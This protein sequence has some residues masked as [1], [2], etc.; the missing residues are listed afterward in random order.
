MAF[1]HGKNTKV[2]YDKYDLSAYFNSVSVPM[3]ADTSET[4]T[5]GKDSKT[6]IAGLKDAT[7]TLEGFFDGSASAV[8]ELLYN[9]LGTD[10]K[11]WSAYQ[12][13]DTIGLP[14]Y[15]MRAVQTAYA[16]N[17]TVDGACTISAATQASGGAERVLSLHAMGAESASDWTG[18]GIDNGAA[19][20]DG[21]SAYLHVTAVT[22]TIAVKIEH[23]TSSDFTTGTADLVT[24]TSVTAAVS[25]RVTFSGTVNRYV[26]GFATIG[27]GETITFNIGVSRA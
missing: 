20:A 2:F 7:M 18:T 25:E 12:S 9:A 24:F 1:A 4:T 16:V 5:F 27:A 10:N 13:G 19:S 17:S 8:D 22:G 6:H 11:L 21:G 26:R 3:T 14:G 15:A 23:S